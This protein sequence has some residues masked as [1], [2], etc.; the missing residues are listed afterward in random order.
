MTIYLYVKT[1]NIT[2]LKYLG[3]TCSEDPYSYAGSGKRW[4]RHLDKHGYDYT[5]EILYTTDDPLDF[6]EVALEYSRFFDVV[7][8]NEWANLMEEN[9]AGADNSHNIDYEVIA[10]TRYMNDKT[11]VQTPE[12]NRKR[13]ESM[14]GRPKSREAV[15]KGLRTKKDKGILHNHYWDKETSPEIAEKVSKALSGVPKS[16]EHI[17]NMGFH[18]NNKPIHE[19]P[20]CGKVGDLRNMK[21]WHFDR[22]KH[23]PDRKDDLDKTVTCYHCGHT[24]KQSPNFYRYHNDN[25]I[26]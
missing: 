20:H 8:S 24:A 4:L 6:R 10:Y 12:S 9:G 17:D 16:Q 18:E 14:R 15:E 23:N 26:Y 22:C 1:H 21:R 25:C 3:K 13:S 7:N 19:C 5:T 11:W 2:G